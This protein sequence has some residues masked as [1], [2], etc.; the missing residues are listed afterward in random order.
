MARIKNDFLKFSG[1]MGGMTFYQD[2]KGTVVKQK[3]EVSKKRIKEH[4]RSQRTRESNMEMGAASMATK[5]MR[6]ALN[7][8]KRGFEDQ[9]FSGR[10]S[11][12][13]RRV[14]G[15]GEGFPGQRKLDIRKNGS[16]LEKFEFIRMRPLVYSLG[17]IKE[18]PTL[19]A[20]RNEIYWTSPTLKRKEQITAPDGATHFKFI[21]G[22]G[23]V[24]NYGYSAA[25][26]MYVP[27]ETKFR[28]VGGFVESEPIGLNQKIIAPIEL[29]IKLT[30]EIALPEELAALTM[31][32]V[33]FLR[34][35][36]GEMLEMED[37][38]AMRVLGVG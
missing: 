26:N 34:N 33:S 24:S 3:S 13:L 9:Y 35:V 17:G 31:V 32:G 6:Q 23:T 19:N 15:L 21:L 28:N 29:Q 5:A 27:L 37:S 8:K 38:L 30:E 10:L 7:S 36:N 2:E 20:E 22:A 18:K 12:Q 4:P 16:L 11:G 25:K 14:V 1:S